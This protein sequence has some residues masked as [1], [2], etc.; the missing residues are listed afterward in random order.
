MGPNQHPSPDIYPGLDDELDAVYERNVA[1][2]LAQPVEPVATKE[3][4]AVVQ[5]QLKPQIP[6]RELANEIYEWA[7]PQLKDALS[8]WDVY[9]GPGSVPATHDLL[10]RKNPN[11]AT[12]MK[13]LYEAQQAL[14][15]SGLLTPENLKA[16]ET[17]RLVLVPWK[18]I[19]EDLLSGDPKRFWDTLKSTRS[20]QGITK[21]DYIHD[22]LKKAID[23]GQSIYRDPD[24]PSKLLSCGEYLQKKIAQDG[25]WGIILAQTSNQAGLEMLKGQSPDLMTGNGK[26]RI[27]VNGEQGGVAHPL[28]SMG[29]FEWLALT[30]QEDPSQLSTHDF[31]WLLANRLDVRGV[32]YVPNGD[33]Y[34]GQVRS[35]LR[36]A[37]DQD[38]GVRPRL[39]VS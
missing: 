32:P 37:D 33:W 20:A 39:A 35:R 4:E 23:E 1:E 36:R 24:D 11:F 10:A 5:E 17:M 38:D 21:E 7:G 8:K 15:E 30:V 9:D 28:D 2:G 16:A 34:D 22:L 31:S 3:L 14:E 12:T 25:D 6:E 29:I 13:R 27:G 18:M 19:A 26:K